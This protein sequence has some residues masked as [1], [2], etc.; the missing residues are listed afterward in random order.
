MRASLL[1]L[2]AAVLFV[3][4]IACAN[5][6][7]LLL[8]RSTKRQHE[9][10]I[11]VA[12]GASRWRLTRQVLVESSLLSFFGAV[13]GLALANSLLKMIALAPENV[14]RL[15]S[16]H[17]D[18]RVI[19]FTFL[20]ALL[21]AVVVGLLPAWQSS[22]SNLLIGLK[23]GGGGASDGAARYRSRNLLVI[24]EV[25]LALMLLTGAG[26]LVRSFISL[27]TVPTGF[28]PEHLAAMTINLSRDSYPDQ[29]R[30]FVRFFGTYARANGRKAQ[31]A[32]FQFHWRP[33]LRDLLL[34]ELR[35]CQPPSDVCQCRP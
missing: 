21:T 35:S 18:R 7:N 2:S 15:A 11:R 8:V 31:P 4:L 1:L 23:E 32:D 30:R 24:A 12:L 33:A 10:S 19:I 26:L 3:L 6:A 22:Q 25:A 20:A 17:L 5:V 13:V 14:Y 16:V 27:Q 29:Q 34:R 9:F 28:Q